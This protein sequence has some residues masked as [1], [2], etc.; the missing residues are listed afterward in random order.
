MYS[1]SHKDGLKSARDKR[2]TKGRQMGDGWATDGR[3]EGDK[4]GCVST[5]ISLTP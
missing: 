2:A 4:P 5:K 1:I 3:Q